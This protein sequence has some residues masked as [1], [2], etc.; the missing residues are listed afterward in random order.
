[1]TGLASLLL[2]L[3]TLAGA[4]TDVDRTWHDDARTKIEWDIPL[5]EGKPH[6]LV[7]QYREDGSVE[8][9]CEYRDGKRHGVQ[10][11][12][13]TSG[14]IAVREIPYA[15]GLA[16][17]LEIR[18]FPDG[19]IQEEIPWRQGQ[20]HGVQKTYTRSGVL[21]WERGW[22]DGILLTSRSWDEHGHPISETDHSAAAKTGEESP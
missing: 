6:G 1:M 11:S 15:D 16:D 8:V 21:V 5:R 12:F 2:G 20:R 14:T 13:D 10:R 22:Q 19:R 9:A 18:R 17:G 4:A 7:R 3:C